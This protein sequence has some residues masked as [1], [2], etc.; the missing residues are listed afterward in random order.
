[1]RVLQK[2][3]SDRATFVHHG[4]QLID[5]DAQRRAGALHERVVRT[6]IDPKNGWNCR[7]PFITDASDFDFL[8]LV[9]SGDLR[10]KSSLEEEN[11]A[12]PFVGPKQHFALREADR[13]Q[14]RAQQCRVG[15]RKN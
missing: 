8:R 10:G 13:F 7:K 14:S 6:A 9:V 2:E 11:M 1:V 12:E 4:S 15:L 3:F 5:T